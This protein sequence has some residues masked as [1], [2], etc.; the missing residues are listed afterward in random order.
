MYKEQQHRIILCK[1]CFTIKGYLFCPG[2]LFIGLKLLI[3]NL[4]RQETEDDIPLIINTLPPPKK[5]K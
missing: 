2:Q 5:E 1:L 4:T 3:T